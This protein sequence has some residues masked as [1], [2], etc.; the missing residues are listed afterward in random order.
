MAQ[1][2]PEE[3]LLLTCSQ[4]GS[5]VTDISIRNDG[6]IICAGC[7]AGLPEDTSPKASSH[8]IGKYTI[9]E[10]LGRGGMG[11]VFQAWD[12]TLQRSVALKILDREEVEEGFRLRFQREARTA[13]SLDHP[14]I[15]RIYEVGRA[16]EKDFIA[17]EYIDGK[18]L[19]QSDLPL[20]VEIEAIAEVAEAVFFAHENG[21]IHRDL[22]P[23][24]IMIDKK[25]RARVMDFGLA[26]QIA[27]G[28]TLTVEG[29]VM[30]TPAYMS[31]EQA[32][33]KGVDHRSDIY[34]LGGLLYKTLCGHP[35][36]HG[37]T[38][39]ETLQKLEKEEI[40][41][42]SQRAA[43][44]PSELETIALKC[45]EKKPNRRYGSAGLV[46]ADLRRWI[47]GDA[48][49]TRRSSALVRGGRRFFQ[50]RFV[51]LSLAVILVGVGF[52]IIFLIERSAENAR[53]SREAASAFD[54]GNWERAEVLYEKAG[55]ESGVFRARAEILAVQ[56]TIKRRK[57][58]QQRAQPLYDSG[59]ARLDK[60][61]LDLYRTGADLSSRTKELR[62]AISE[63][64][65][66][67]TI[68]PDYG[69]AYLQR[70]WTWLE[71]LEYEKARDDFGAAM[72]WIPSHPDVYYGKGWA[73]LWLAINLRMS[74]G[75]TPE[76][77]R[78]GK[79]A[80]E[81]SFKD[82]TT[83]QQ[84]PGTDP[85]KV[86]IS[87]LLLVYF[88]GDFEKA[89]EIS[90]AMIKAGGSHELIYYLHAL[91]LYGQLS[92][93]KD[94]DRDELQ[95]SLSESI[96]RRVNFF[97]AYTTRASF[98]M[99]TQNFN[100]ALADYIRASEI[101]P[102]LAE[103]KGNIGYCYIKL[104]EWERAEK[105]LKEAIEI[106]PENAMSLNNLGYLYSRIGKY[107][108]SLKYL[109]LAIELAPRN[110]YFLT[111]RG[112]VRWRLKQYEEAL[113]DLNEAIRIAPGY[114]RSYVNR[115]A[116][117]FE[118]KEW[119]L[120][121]AD[122]RSFIQKEK[123]LDTTYITVVYNLGI[124]SHELGEYSEA[125]KYWEVLRQLKFKPQLIQQ[126][127]DRTER[128]MKK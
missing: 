80:Q 90:A 82:F 22:K 43:N 97:E 24:N 3:T 123:V 56:T 41:P 79:I 54:A 63:F 122:F 8:R 35:P 83:F 16:D 73:N 12:E 105:A 94:V 11:M 21:I 5:R 29:S 64:T 95:Q 70:G 53:L 126:L 13:A 65:S 117:Y 69:E 76:M 4:C 88:K 101:N 104:E 112:S 93:G 58:S 55:D 44:V 19:S 116:V 108:E 118:N 23:Q 109:G 20:R 128:M 67:V 89:R 120:A 66:V 92:R 77:M 68:C 103:M 49:H 111:T 30:G 61:I 52:G 99:E 27:G 84:M 37:E 18:T 46:G 17:Q 62:K 6:E 15:V 110:P 2:D 51:L 107:P 10:L 100:G 113:Q 9:T 38:P 106:D 32:E 74:Q 34:S 91:I 7:S 102:T 115:G 28:D 48:I 50:N 42:P 114:S 33:G 40:V 47:K 45:L 14:G 125:L 98:Y 121:A 71:L 119:A 127:K 57:E 60:A 96:R 85:E 75:A 86:V 78:L 25:G 72:K 31:V 81:M 124:C 1:E 36:F 39:L 87:E 26:K 59:K